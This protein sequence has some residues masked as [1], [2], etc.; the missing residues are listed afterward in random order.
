MNFLQKLSCWSN[1]ELYD[2]QG[3]VQWGAQGAWAPPLGPSLPDFMNWFSEILYYLSS[4]SLSGTYQFFTYF[5]HWLV[6]L[7]YKTVSFCPG[8]AIQEHQA[9]DHESATTSAK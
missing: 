1:K 2:T 9:A 5:T 4:G 7:F 8:V 6:T 3:R